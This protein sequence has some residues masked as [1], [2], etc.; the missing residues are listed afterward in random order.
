VKRA[1]GPSSSGW[2][3]GHRVDREDHVRSTDPQ[4]RRSHL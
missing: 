1:A 3:H 2:L 4:T